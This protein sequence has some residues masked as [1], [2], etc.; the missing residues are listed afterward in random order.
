MNGHDVPDRDGHAADA[1]DGLAPL[2]PD[3]LVRR[4]STW[5]GA[6]VEDFRLTWEN[7]AWTAT[8]RVGREDVQYVVRLSPTWQ[9]RQFLLFRDLDE[10]DLWLFA[11]AHARWGEMNGAARSELDGCIDLDVDCSPSTDTVP[12]RRLRLHEGDAGEVH[13]V[14]VDVETLSVERARRRYH[15][16]GPRRYAYDDLESGYRA[17]FDVDEHGFVIDHPGR[18]RRVG[19]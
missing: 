3:G 10:P 4:W 13:T 16:I 2:P 8:G 18:Y 7:E 14:V 15:R 6:H 1:P 12:I 17:E 5:D 9:V 19:H 11:D